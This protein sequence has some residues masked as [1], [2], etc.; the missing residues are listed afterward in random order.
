MAQL[1]HN[2]RDIVKDAD[3]HIDTSSPQKVFKQLQN[4]VLLNQNTQDRAK[5][6]DKP[7]TLKFELP[8]GETEQTTENLSDQ[9]TNEKT[10]LVIREIDI[11]DSFSQTQSSQE[12]QV[13]HTKSQDV[14]EK[15]NGIKLPHNYEAILK[16]ADSPINKS[17]PNKI[18]DQLYSGKYWVNKE[19]GS[20]CFMLFARDLSVIWGDDQ[21]YWKWTSLKE[22][23]DV[24]VDVAELLNVCWLEIKVRFETTK[25]T[26]RALY[27]VMFVI[28]LKEVAYGWDAP[29]NLRL[30]L[31]NGIKI[32]HKE[33]LKMKPRNQWIEIPVGEF[34]TLPER[35]GEMEISMYEIEDENWKKGLVI[36]GI[37][38]TA[39]E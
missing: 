34:R 13:S 19:S 33:N 3:S 35:A 26:P 39:K 24:F 8:N 2:L 18:K 20:N 14:V 17:S 32:E 21:R 30:L 38:I 6:W 28:M 12:V 23:S 11:T 9:E 10:R 4:G 27:K 5:G 31:P 36:K 1:P 25:L 29:V 16:E 22:T 7:V 37:V 15:T